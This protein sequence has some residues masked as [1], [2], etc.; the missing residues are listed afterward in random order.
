MADGVVNK[1]S[2]SIDL[3]QAN[4]CDSDEIR[5]KITL[6]N[7]CNEGKGITWN[8]SY[9]LLEEFVKTAFTQHGK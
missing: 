2:C 8:D 5:D 9:E 7:I 6:G 3:N 1:S 4:G